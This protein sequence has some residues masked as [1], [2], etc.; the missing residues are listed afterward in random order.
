VSR[1]EKNT[2]NT[3][4]VV[5]TLEKSGNGREAAGKLNRGHSRRVGM[6]AEFWGERPGEIRED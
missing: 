4:V 2:N 1:W 5:D 3:G 6:G